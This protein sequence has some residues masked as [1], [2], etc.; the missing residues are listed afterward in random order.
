MS[1]LGKA[2]KTPG[3]LRWGNSIAPG[4][5]NQPKIIKVVKKKRGKSWLKKILTFWRKD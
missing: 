4:K 5:L 2:N 1:S 3:D